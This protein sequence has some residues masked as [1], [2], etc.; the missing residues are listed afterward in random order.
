MVV[1]FFLSLQQERRERERETKSC[2]TF[3]GDKARAFVVSKALKISLKKKEQKVK[4]CVG[5]VKIL[6]LNI[7]FYI[8]HG[9]SLSLSSPYLSSSAS[10]LEQKTRARRRRRLLSYIVF[11]GIY[12]T[13]F[14]SSV[15]ATVSPKSAALI[16]SALFTPR[17]IRSLRCT[18][19]TNPS[20]WH[21]WLRR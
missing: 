2:C 9:R 1:F 19:C 15:F 16:S 5:E 7:F 10:R 17:R 14:Y 11:Y 6:F 18:W 12:F 4:L 8:T 21:R 3:C 20:T 13:S